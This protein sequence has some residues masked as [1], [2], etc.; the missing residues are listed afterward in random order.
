MDR[1]ALFLVTGFM[2]LARCCLKFRQIRARKK[3]TAE[4]IRQ[5]KEMERARKRREI[6]RG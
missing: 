4:M 5:I 1:D 2:L 3:R 6:L